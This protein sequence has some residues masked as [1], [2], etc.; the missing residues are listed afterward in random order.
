MYG[1]GFGRRRGMEEGLMEFFVPHF[2]IRDG[3]LVEPVL[4]ICWVFESIAWTEM[5][6]EVFIYFFLL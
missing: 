6:D 5:D 2:F 1:L 4:Y 3:V